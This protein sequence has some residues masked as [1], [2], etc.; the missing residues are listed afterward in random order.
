MFQTEVYIIRS[1]TNMVCL[2]PELEA[3]GLCIRDSKYELTYVYSLRIF[4]PQ[5]FS[6]PLFTLSVLLISSFKLN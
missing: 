3:R 2:A 5:V 1:V 4:S 6:C